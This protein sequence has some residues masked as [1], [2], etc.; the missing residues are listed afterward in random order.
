MKSKIKC[1]KCSWQPTLKDLW[2]CTC[3]HEWNTFATGGICEKCKKRWKVT[4]CFS[5]RKFSPHLDWYSSFD[6]LLKIELAEISIP[7]LK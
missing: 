1:P 7:V 4:Q 6:K 5:C 2:Q 3:S